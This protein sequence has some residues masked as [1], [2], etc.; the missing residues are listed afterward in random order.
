MNCLNRTFKWGAAATLGIAASVTA[1]PAASS[2]AIAP[3]T[4]SV[5]AAVPWS[6]P[7]PDRSIASR[8]VTSLKAKEIAKI[9]A[10]MRPYVAYAKQKYWSNGTLTEYGRGYVGEMALGYLVASGTDWNDRLA[11]QYKYPG[12]PRTY[13]L[14]SVNPGGPFPDSTV[15]WESKVNTS[16][17]TSSQAQVDRSVSASYSENVA[18]AWFCVAPHDGTVYGVKWDKEAP[19]I[20][21]IAGIV[22]SGY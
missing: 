17:L 18:Y 20:Y 19:W 12:K 4:S 3:I 22:R 11:Y 10:A 5:K 6:C 9:N 1:L 14:R 2:F 15:Y 8:T 13:D 21:K 7:S 16:K